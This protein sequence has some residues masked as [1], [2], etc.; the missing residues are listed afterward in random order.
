[1]D[2]IR[3][4]FKLEE[5]K[6]HSSKR[7]GKVPSK[8]RFLHLIEEFAGKENI[9]G[10]FVL[11]H[12]KDYAKSWKA[13]YNRNLAVADANTYLLISKPLDL[14]DVDENAKYLAYAGTSMSSCQRIYQHLTE[15]PKNKRVR[16]LPSA[17]L[18]RTSSPWDIGLFF[19]RH[20]SKA[21][22]I[23]KRVESFLINALRQMP[24]FYHLNVNNNKQGMASESI[25]SENI[26]ESVQI[27]SYF[28]SIINCNLQNIEDTD[29]DEFNK[30]FDQFSLENAAFKE[31]LRKTC[32]R[33]RIED[34]RMQ[35]LE[36]I[37]FGFDVMSMTEN[38]KF[39]LL[40]TLKELLQAKNIYSRS[41][42]EASIFAKTKLDNASYAEIEE[43]ET[44]IEFIACHKDKTIKE[45]KDMI[46]ILNGVHK[47]EFYN[48][49][50]N[51]HA[52]A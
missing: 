29:I 6:F 26:E 18:C 44:K 11:C 23:N 10:T 14:S 43:Y 51:E 4:G 1:M 12:V 17:V 3:N 21:D 9:S 19:V 47:P 8:A 52:Y 38:N 42:I 20:P 48:I 22:V 50:K 5:Q 39:N 25:V 46:K 36:K 32:K 45:V 7:L 30:V 41:F 37:H 27:A 2:L 16:D 15:L 13:L 31:K 33:D 49:Q 35:Q 40:E 24:N 34:Y 28:K